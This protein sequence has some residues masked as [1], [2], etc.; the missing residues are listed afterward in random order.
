MES[1]TFS[2]RRYV[3][4]RRQA[5]PDAADAIDPSRRLTIVLRQPVEL[6]L[7]ELE[8]TVAAHQLGVHGV[9]AD[10]RPQVQRV[11]G[12]AAEAGR[13]QVGAVE[14]NRGLPHRHRAAG[15]VHRVA[16]VAALVAVPEG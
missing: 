13:E 9:R 16:E 5:A 4:Y 7:G 1:A 15:A 10:L 2:A 11:G 14:A 12:G 3:R 6:P 8:V